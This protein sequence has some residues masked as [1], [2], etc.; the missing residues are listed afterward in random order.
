MSQTQRKHAY[1]HFVSVLLILFLLVA[2]GASPSGPSRCAV[3][4]GRRLGLAQGL[5]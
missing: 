2:W 3:V 5:S 4:S 1:A